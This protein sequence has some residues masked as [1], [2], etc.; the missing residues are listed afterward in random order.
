M[1]DFKRDSEEL[2][3]RNLQVGNLLWNDQDGDFCFVTAIDHNDFFV[4]NVSNGKV[5]LNK[6]LE[7]PISPVPITEPYLRGL[8]FIQS[9]PKELIFLISYHGRYHYLEKDDSFSWWYVFYVDGKPIKINQHELI[10]VHQIQNL[11]YQ[12]T[13]KLLTYDETKEYPT[14]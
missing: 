1:S 11:Y 4:R 10:Y 5:W 6:C 13:N 14:E 9:R 3:T 12:L 2:D 7:I 8:G